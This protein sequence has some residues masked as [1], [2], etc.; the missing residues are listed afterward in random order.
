M[1]MQ[2]EFKCEDGGI[3]QEY[4]GCKIEYDPKVPIMKL[5]QPVLIKSL[6][7][8]FGVNKM[9]R[10]SSVPAT[11][12]TVLNRNEEEGTEV[13]K[14]RM[15]SGVGKLLHL[16]RWSRPEIFN[17]VRELTRV[18]SVASK[19]HLNAM[20]K[21]MTYCVET[22]QRGRVIKP[23]SL[24]NGKNDFEFTIHGKSDSD[25]A[26]EPI[27]RKSVSGWSVFLNRASIR[28]SLRCRIV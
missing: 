16:V 26:K 3:L 28:R 9:G 21:C 8:E 27:E 5:T 19:A 25:F 20:K 7:D 17:A 14:T 10:E 24:W 2:Q 12:G 18:T 4:V 6:V 11:A 15:R 13:D 1:L 23:D 22:K